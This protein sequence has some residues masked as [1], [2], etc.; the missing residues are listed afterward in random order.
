[1]CRTKRIITFCAVRGC[2]KALLGCEWSEFLLS[3]P[4]FKQY[5]NKLRSKNTF[6]KKK[7]LEIAE[8]TAE[9]GILQ[10]TEELLRQ[11]HE[12]IQQQLVTRARA[13]PPALP[14]PGTA[15]GPQGCCLGYSDV[16]HPQLL[17]P[18]LKEPLG[19]KRYFCLL[20]VRL[21]YFVS[22]RTGLQLLF[23]LRG[24]TLLFKVD[25]KSAQ[26]LLR[27]RLDA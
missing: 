25:D 10:R 16:Y 22:I 24:L 4:Q 26:I 3:L 8:I 13:A 5:V 15:L 19:Y 2:G 23:R 11:R 14:A 12:A 6:Y 20:A 27:A 18:L 17:L 9:Y 7:R 1:M 21:L